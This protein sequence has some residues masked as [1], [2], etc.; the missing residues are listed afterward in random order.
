[1]VSRN[2]ENMFLKICLNVLT[3][4]ILTGIFRIIGHISEK[5]YVPNI[6]VFFVKYGRICP[7]FWTFFQFI[8]IF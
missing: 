7:R 3:N 1:M 8:Q 6:Y 4:I 2:L 5:R